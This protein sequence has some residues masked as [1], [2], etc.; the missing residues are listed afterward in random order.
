MM[1]KLWVTEILSK[2]NIEEAKERIDRVPDQNPFTIKYETKIP[3]TEDWEAS[4][5]VLDHDE[6]LK[7]LLM[8]W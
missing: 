4:T 6:K 3:A 2:D 5:F 8:G 1:A 7:Q